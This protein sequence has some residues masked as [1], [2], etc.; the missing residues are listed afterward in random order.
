M[1]RIPRDE[2][3]RLIAYGFSPGLA[4]L[5]PASLLA[6]GGFDHV[7]T[8]TA[9]RPAGIRPP[10]GPRRRPLPRRSARAR[11]AGPSAGSDQFIRLL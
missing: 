10:P 3:G 2:R 11:R 5:P 8:V 6:V 7:G 9:Q 1:M 4:P